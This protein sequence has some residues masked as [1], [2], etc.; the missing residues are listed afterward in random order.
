MRSSRA[1]PWLEGEGEESE[2]ES[3]RE[4]GI[5]PGVQGAGRAELGR[6]AWI[7]QQRRKVYEGWDW[8]PEREPQL[9]GD[10]KATQGKHRLIIWGFWGIQQDMGEE[11]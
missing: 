7:Y 8:F 6:R 2:L 10:L 1:K 4:K 3:R 11:G 9:W 5:I